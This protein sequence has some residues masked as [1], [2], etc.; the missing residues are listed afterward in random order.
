[1]RR[2]RL[3][4][5]LALYVALFV[6]GNANAQWR[7]TTPRDTVIVGANKGQSP[8]ISK[9]SLTSGVEVWLQATG[10]WNFNVG[11]QSTFDAGYTM[12]HPN[13]TLP[14]PIKNPP[15]Y[16]NV[17]Y[18]YGLK[19]VTF[20][21]RFED[22]F[23]PIEA[24][25]IQHTYTS[26]VTNTGNPIS[27]YI[28][29]PNASY[30]PTATGSITV[31]LARWTAGIAVKE[32]DVKFGNVR[33]G[34]PKTILD[35]IASYGVDPLVVQNIEIFG[36]DSAD[37][38]F[39]S[40]RDKAFTLPSEQANEIAITFSPSRLGTA[41]A[42]LKITCKNTDQTSREQY[43]QLTGNGQ[44]PILDKLQDT[45]DFGKVRIGYP[46]T[47]PLSIYNKG[48]TDLNV[49]GAT[50]S[51]LPGNDFSSVTNIPFKV[52]QGSVLQ[53]KTKFAPTQRGIYIGRVSVTTDSRVDSTVLI[54]EGAEPAPVFSRKLIS[55]GTVYNGNQATDTFVMKNIGNWTATIVRAAIEG[56]NVFSFEP[57]DSSF[58]LEPDSSRMFTVTFHPGSTLNR[59]FRAW[60]IFAYDD[61]LAVH[62][63]VELIGTE[64]QP[65]V[66]F[67]PVPNDRI[68]NF[69]KVKIGAAKDS[70]ITS[71]RN[72]GNI[73]QVCYQSVIPS[74]PFTITPVPRIEPN[75]S[76]PLLGK[77]TPLVPGPAQAWLYNTASGYKDSILLI[78]EG[79]VAKA[80]FDPNPLDFGIVPSNKPDTLI[81]T[82]TDSGNYPLRIIR[83]EI[84]GPK[85]SSFSILYTTSGDKTPPASS[86]TPYTLQ[87]MSSIPIQV[88]FWTN[89]RT[90]A[91]HN[92]TLCVYYDD[93]TF[94]CLP[95]QAIEE[96]Q[97][98]QFASPAVDFGR[99]RVKTRDTNVVAFKNNSNIELSVANVQATAVTDG[100]TI[101]GSPSPVAPGKTLEV[102]VEFYPQ[103]KQ[104]YLGY[105]KAWGGD[106]AREDSIQLRGIGAA[107][108]PIFSDTI[109][110]FGSVQ[111]NAAYP[112]AIRRVTL[113]NKGDWDLTRLSVRLINENAANEFGGIVTGGEILAPDSSIEFEVTFTPT[114]TI[115]YH[116]ADLVFTFD[117]STLGVVHLIGLDE[118]PNIVIGEDTVR[119]GRVRLSTTS[120]PRQAH[121]INTTTKTLTA[122]NVRIEPSPGVFASAG[123]P[124]AVSV[125]PNLIGRKLPIDITFTPAARGIVSAKLL[126]DG[127]DALPDT[128]VLIGEG[129]EPIPQFEPSGTLDFGQVLYGRQVTLTFTIRNIGNWEYQNATISITGPNSADFTQ[130]IFPNFFIEP[131]STRTFSVT[132]RATPPMDTLADRKATLT[133]TIDD[134]TQYAYELLARDRGPYATYLKF[135]NL[136]ARPGDIVY[137]NLRLM[138][139][140]PDSL[141]IDRL[142]GVILYDPNVVRL[143]KVEAGALTQNWTITEVIPLNSIPGRYEYQLSS[144]TEW[145]SQPGSLLRL[146]FKALETSKAGEYSNLT[147]ETFDFPQRM[148]VQGVLTNGVI[149]IDSACGS[150]NL[151]TGKIRANYIEQSS[152]NP[153]S[154]SGG[155][156]TLLFKVGVDDTPVT[157]RIVDVTGNE[158]ARPVDGV[159]LKQGGY[160]LKVDRS[161]ISASGTYFYEFRAG[162]DKPVMRKMVIA[163]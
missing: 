149:V 151:V 105:A 3:F 118:S 34:S 156:T 21:G 134:N 126:I 102:P 73:P 147:H 60:L 61:I 97:Y 117:D 122:A 128:A 70:L 162:N 101:I 26:R 96:K 99:V 20:L 56:D 139:M 135:D 109:V 50:Y 18:E 143:Q 91:P 146:T 145:L 12:K 43:V 76:E 119:F 89:D 42:T 78:G 27:F 127:G 140:L 47:K 65:P 138:N 30:Y 58:I 111:L 98:L 41:S 130:M 74:K 115:V 90:G 131:D 25:N 66:V 19:V 133:F 64:L 93:S 124:G 1:M 104:S 71:L 57:T 62:D 14:S 48:N 157:I 16:G 81:T 88:R 92:A 161:M 59:N 31:K 79:A 160:K 116:S 32:K 123:L 150:P 24:Y 53:I 113:Y 120:P 152:P 29:G 95:L 163:D 13:W 80:V 159:P 52:P 49:T 136:S 45:L 36:P 87:E 68:F 2:S 38:S 15:T 84:T 37:F 7:I 75:K 85:A 129:A 155:G 83:Y 22:W 132:F 103:K 9:I 5:G 23:K 142:E 8:S 153:A 144:Q 33:L 125:D 40:Q 141:Q 55:F 77:F 10:I 28:M 86:Q 46:Q 114:Q 63:S 107:P 154:L 94:D 108:A 148:E 6:F 137:P 54:G 158:I 100:F 106:F 44:L 11:G 72:T 51:A 39:V 67:V 121:L 112:G 35:S 17:T 69:G 110:D 4:G 82:L